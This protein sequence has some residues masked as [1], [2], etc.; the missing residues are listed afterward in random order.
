[1][2]VTTRTRATDVIMIGGHEIIYIDLVCRACAIGIGFCFL[3]FS[4]HL[5]TGLVCLLVF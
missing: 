4:L 5:S 1:M 3:S 2:V